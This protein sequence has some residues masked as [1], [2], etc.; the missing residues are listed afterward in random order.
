MN[1]ECL[2]S[3]SLHFLF[4]GRWSKCGGEATMSINGLHAFLLD[5]TRARQKV[6]LPQFAKMH[7]EKTEKQPELLCDFFSVLVW[8]CS[9][10]DFQ[11]LDADKISVYSWLYGNHSKYYEEKMVRFVSTIRS[12]GLEPVFFVGCCPLTD[13]DCPVERELCHLCRARVR[14]NSSSILQVCLGQC[15]L[16][17][18]QWSLREGMVHD[19]T[20][21]LGSRYEVRMIYCGGNVA[22]EA[23]PYMKANKN[24]CGILARDTSFAIVPHCGLFLLDFFPSKLLGTGF[25][26][27]PDEDVVCE[28]VWSS[29]LASALELEESQLMD[30]AILSGNLYTT[31]WNSQLHPCDLLEIVKPDVQ[32]IAT[33]MLK[34]ST[35]LVSNPLLQDFLAENPCYIKAIELSYQLYSGDCPGYDSCPAFENYRRQAGSSGSLVPMLSV[36]RHQIFVW[37]VLI[38]PNMVKEPRFCYATLNI[39]KLIYALLGDNVAS[40][41]A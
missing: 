41:M 20:S 39:R 10:S 13:L 25:V 5:A 17:K 31:V 7:L 2:L 35:A 4:V 28:V 37:P 29:L 24:A 15:E 36:F 27:K 23:I 8:I 3:L 30:L 21:A 1:V 11:L 33:W 34:Q 38:E 16:C 40:S 12:F 26:L 9:A 32:S 19:V 22:A 18:V 14:D 6:G